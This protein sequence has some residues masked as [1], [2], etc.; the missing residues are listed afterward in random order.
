MRAA[1]AVEALHDLA[2]TLRDEGTSQMDLFALYQKFQEQTA[3]DDP[4]Y[5]A[6]VDMMDL[7]RG[8]PWA[9]GHALFSTELGD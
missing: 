2:V 8:G 6:I 5:D 1:N 3:G 4:R 9:K 7:I